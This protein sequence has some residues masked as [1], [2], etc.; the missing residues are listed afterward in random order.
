MNDNPR[1]LLVYEAEFGTLLKESLDAEGYDVQIV[2]PYANAELV[3]QELRRVQ[4]DVVIPTNS[5]FSAYGIS[6]LVT[7]IKS[8]FPKMKILVIASQDDV[9]YALD[10]VKRGVSDYLTMPFDLKDVIA[11]LNRIMK[12]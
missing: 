11:T 8:E 12:A 3:L 7:S 5:G 1:I 9:K 10:L 2:T 6:A 4:Y